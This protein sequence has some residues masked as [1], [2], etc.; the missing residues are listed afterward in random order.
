VGR[1]FVALPSGLVTFVFTDIEG[2]TRLFRRIGNRYATLLDRHRE[3]LR[4]A[5]TRFDGREVGI[6]RRADT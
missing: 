1:S 2:S 3:L 5:W 4:A 6:P